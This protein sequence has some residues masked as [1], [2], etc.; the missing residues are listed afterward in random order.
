[1]AG[2]GVALKA[3]DR[4]EITTLVDNSIDVFSIQNRRDSTAA[5]TNKF[6]VGRAQRACFR[7][8]R[9]SFSQ[10]S[11]DCALGYPPLQ[12]ECQHRCAHLQYGCARNTIAARIVGVKLWR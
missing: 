12:C 3:L 7:A 6:A 4:L 2:T 9:L 1:V 10:A 5:D 11:D 8:R